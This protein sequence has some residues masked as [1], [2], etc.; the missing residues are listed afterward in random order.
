MFGAH[1]L[2]NTKLDDDDDEK[3]FYSTNKYSYK[4]KQQ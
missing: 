4:I 1:E 3:N 2:S